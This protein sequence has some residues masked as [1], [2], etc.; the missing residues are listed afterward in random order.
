MKFL[1]LGISG[2]DGQILQKL[3]NKYEIE[4]FGITHRNKKLIKNLY[5]WDNSNEML[6][7][8]LD[9]VSP[10]VI[11]NFSAVH[12]SSLSLSNINFETMYSVNTLNVL[13]ILEV[14]KTNF[15]HILYV[16][17]LTSHMYSEDKNQVINEETK[18]NP[19]N[20]YGLTKYHS[21]N[22]AEYYEKHFD[23]KVL[24]LI[25]FNHESEF[26]KDEFI[27]K[28]IS[29]FIAKAYKNKKTEITVNNAFKAEDFSDAYDF[30]EALI[31][32]CS[33]NETGRFVLSS[34]GLYTIRDL[35]LSTGKKFGIKNVVIESSEKK[36]SNSIYGNNEKLLATGFKFNSNIFEALNRM[37]LERIKK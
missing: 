12:S 21:L 15:P 26:R 29:N 37:V 7:S 19:R 18:I 16:N 35:I 4:V 1:V 17:S 2:Q 31:Y 32:L 30:I 22:I 13:T 25:M 6:T 27:S 10:D 14:I 34:N 8:I 23:T 9:E 3:S 28:K 24:N 5:F 36:S 11:V 33:K 20:F